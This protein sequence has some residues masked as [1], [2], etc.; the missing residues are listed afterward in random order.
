MEL[1]LGNKGIYMTHG[2]NTA[3]CGMTQQLTEENAE[4]KYTEG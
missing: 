4:L 3:T 1:E 2:G